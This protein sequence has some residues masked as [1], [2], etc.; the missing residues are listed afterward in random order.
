MITMDLIKRNKTD[1][2]AH[3]HTHIDITCFE[4]NT[5]YFLESSDNV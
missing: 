1:V 2:R 4:R 5:S 3:T